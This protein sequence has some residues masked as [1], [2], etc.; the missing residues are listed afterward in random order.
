MNPFFVLSVMFLLLTFC[1]LLWVDMCEVL[2]AARELN[3]SSLA[4]AV[5]KT[6]LETSREQGSFRSVCG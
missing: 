1:L 5:S 3:D 4:I 6:Y 2:E